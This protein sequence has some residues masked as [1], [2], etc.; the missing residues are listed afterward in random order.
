MSKKVTQLRLF[1]I[2]HDCF[3]TPE[4]ILLGIEETKLTL[5]ELCSEWIFQHELGEKERKHHLQCFARL[6]E[7]KKTRPGTLTKLLNSLNTVGTYRALICSDKGKHALRTYCMKPGTR[8]SGPWADKPIYMGEDLPSK[9]K[10]W[11]IDVCKHLDTKV[12]RKIRWYYD[13]VG[14]KGKSTLSKWLY[15]HK[16]IVTLTFGNAGDL[17]NLVSKF[18]GRKGYIF[19][20]SRTKGGK[21][22]MSDIYQAM[23]SVAN[24]YFVN[25]KY[26]CSIVCMNA[27]HV[28]VFS[29]HLPDKSCLSADRWEIIYMMPDRPKTPELDPVDYESDGDWE[30]SPMSPDLL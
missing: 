16:K 30:M 9:L 21:T 20:L 25:T 15:Y 24:G 28:V 23:E 11:Q 1:S 12:T 27:P 2:I 6:K 3:K 29:N 13:N 19:D 14:G 5:S 17:L 18:Q 10:P 22:S 4:E 7:S 8:I 26:E